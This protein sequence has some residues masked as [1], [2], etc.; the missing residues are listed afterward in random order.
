MPTKMRI[1]LNRNGIIALLKSREVHDD[2]MGRAQRIADAAGGEEA[3]FVATESVSPDRAAVQ[4]K[5]TTLE[6]RRREAHDRTLTQAIWA[7][8]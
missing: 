8:K 1:E 4:I 6:A 2:L 7:G 3:G 5:T